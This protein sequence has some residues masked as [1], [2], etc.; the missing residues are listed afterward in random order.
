MM[1][2][3]EQSAHNLIDHFRAVCRGHIPLNMVWSREDQNAAGVD[4]RSVDFIAHLNYIVQSRGMGA[5]CNVQAK[6]NK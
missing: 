4:D 5:R 2:T 6:V 1:G 3:W